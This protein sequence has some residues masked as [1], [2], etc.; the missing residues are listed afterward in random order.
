MD[1]KRLDRIFIGF[2]ASV[3]LVVV[4]SMLFPVNPM[5]C[6]AV[7]LLGQAWAWSGK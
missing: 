4:L 2:L 5:A 6:L 3:A 7:G 1:I